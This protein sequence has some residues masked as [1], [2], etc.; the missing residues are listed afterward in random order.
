MELSSY[1][2]GLR[3]DL[4]R[5]AAPGGEDARRVAQA[6]MDALEPAVRLAMMGVLASAAE[7]ITA[8]LGDAAVEVRLTG[9]EPQIVV[10]GLEPPPPPA[11]GDQDMVRITLRLPERLKS[12]VEEMASRDGVSV[13][14]WL[15]QAVG[16]AADQPAG[17][18]RN[19][20][21]RG[22]ARG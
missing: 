12:R 19:R 7:E 9:R 6:L 11:D 21:L 3:A 20:T 5:S 2:D 22:Y 10:T 16:R 8:A 1:V 13:N 17:A 15:V 4:Q 18:R 14:S